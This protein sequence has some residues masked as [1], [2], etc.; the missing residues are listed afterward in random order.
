VSQASRLILVSPTLVGTIEPSS[1]ILVC[2]TLPLTVRELDTYLVF[3]TMSE[4]PPT[5]VEL[6]R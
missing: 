3:R 6:S 2:P 1:S 4:I 5:A